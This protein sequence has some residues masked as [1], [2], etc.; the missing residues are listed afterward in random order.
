MQIARIYYPLLLAQRKMKQKGSPS[1]YRRIGVDFYDLKQFRL[2]IDFRMASRPETKKGLIA[3]F[4]FLL[5]D[6]LQ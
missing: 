3:P 4:S 1:R 5:S 2:G 6:L